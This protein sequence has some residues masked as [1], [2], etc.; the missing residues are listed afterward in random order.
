M[1]SECTAWNPNCKTPFLPAI[2]QDFYPI[3]DY[4]EFFTGHVICTI[5]RRE[6]SVHA[7]LSRLCPV[8]S[9]AIDSHR[10]TAQKL[11]ADCRFMLGEVRDSAS[12]EDACS[13]SMGFTFGLG[14]NWPWSK[15]RVSGNKPLWEIEQQNQELQ[16]SED[17]SYVDVKYPSN[18]STVVIK[19]WR[20]YFILIQHMNHPAPW[21]EDE[22]IAKEHV[23]VDYLLV[24]PYWQAFGIII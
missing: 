22:Q 14:W 23:Y 3:L 7:T 4:S 18:I 1:A 6:N 21:L 17:G 5:L 11:I 16:C 8:K 24:I 19:I 20:M 13:K 12:S 2:D 9:S 15:H 10:T